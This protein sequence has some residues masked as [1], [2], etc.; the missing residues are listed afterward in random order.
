[1]IPTDQAVLEWMP[2]G[3]VVCDED[4]TIVFV[5]RQ[6]ESITGY[7]RDELTGKKIERLVPLRSRPAHSNLRSE[8]YRRGRPRLMG[9]S[10]DLQLRRKDGS[11]LAVDIAL[12]PVGR[13]T[14]AAIRDVTERRNMEQALAHRALHDPLTELANRSLFFDRLRL[15][16]GD[17]RRSGTTVALVM[18][19]VDGFKAVNDAYGHSVGDEVL[20]TLAARLREGLRATDTAARIGGDEFAWIMPHVAS[21]RA[22]Q[23]AV[24]KR[25]RG[26]QQHVVVRR[27]K[28]AIAVSAGV[29][30]YP[31]DARDADTLIRHADSAMYAA[32]REGRGVVFHVAPP[33]R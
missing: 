15:A 5:N 25:L 24:R 33:A 18:L 29:A 23:S 30:L 19:D 8:F 11:L 14:V 26:V 32:K 28:I 16:L 17:A 27:R 3:V 21:R 22:V 6:A 10:T 9:A 31:E 2:D 13:Q 4:G 1:M 12:G 20:R 7:T